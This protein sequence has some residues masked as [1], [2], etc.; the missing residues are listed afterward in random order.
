MKN[1]LTILMTTLF[2][3]GVTKAQVGILP[4]D[5]DG[6]FGGNGTGTQTLPQRGFAGKVIIKSNDEI[7]VNQLYYL[8]MI[9]PNGGG[10]KSVSCP[11]VQCDALAMSGNYII[12][13]GITAAGELGITRLDLL[14]RTDPTFGT[15]G[16]IKY[17]LSNAQTTIPLDCVFYGS[18]FILTGSV[19]FGSGRRQFVA[20]YNANGTPDFSF[21]GLGYTIE[22]DPVWSQGSSVATQANNIV[23]GGASV[24]KG[25][26]LVTL[27][28]YADNGFHQVNFNS[29][30]TIKMAGVNEGV[31]AV[32]PNQQILFGNFLFNG[33][34]QTGIARFNP[35]GTLDT[36]FGQMGITPSPV[37]AYTDFNTLRVDSFGRIIAVGRWDQSSPANQMIVARYLTN[38]QIDT[39]FNYTGRGSTAGWRVFN[40]YSG[41]YQ[42]YFGAGIQSNGKIVV[43]GH[44]GSFSGTNVI[45]RFNGN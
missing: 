4:A 31:V 14:L 21:G 39:N 9:K 16:I 24:E 23:V 37:T 38:G 43:S 35:N 25:N 6:L 1:F 33:G 2:V 22:S 3:F 26:S 13:A 18:S 12:W 44:A 41:Q 10:T 7:I 34:Y 29:G 30:K 5:L 19:D 8:T 45:Y 20:K 17:R 36:F 11:F 28:V 42:Q 32:Q 15:N 27:T 40:S